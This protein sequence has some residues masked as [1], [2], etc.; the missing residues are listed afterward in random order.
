M[1]EKARIIIID[2]DAQLVE[3]LK[4]YLENKGHYVK[5]ALNSEQALE[6]LQK[7]EFDI[8][9]CDYNLPD[10]KGL[11]LAMKIAEKYP[12]TVTVFVTG[13]RSMGLAMEAMRKGV[14]DYIVKPIDYDELDK[15]IEEILQE[16]R[17]FKEGRE[18]EQSTDFIEDEGLQKS[19]S[20]SGRDK[21]GVEKSPQGKKQRE[22]GK[23]EP[24][25][26]PRQ[27]A[28]EEY[29]FSEVEDKE[30]TVFDFVID[31]T[32]ERK[33]Q[34]LT[35][36]FYLTLF[37]VAFS[38]VDTFFLR[39]TVV[40]RTI[41][42]RI[43]PPSLEIESIPSGANIELYTESGRN[44]VRGNERT[45]AQIESITPGRYTLSLTKDGYS[46]VEKTVQVSETDGEE[47]S[48]LIPGSERE[49][50]DRGTQRFTIPFEVVFNINSLPSG[51]QVFI[52]D[53]RM[54]DET[55]VEIEM[56]ID[57]YNIVLEKEGYEHLGSKSIRDMTGRCLIDL[58]PGSDNDIDEESWD[59]ER[60]AGKINL[61]GRFW[62]NV[63]VTSDPEGANV[64][65]NDRL[66]GR[67]PLDERMFS[68]V[69]QFRFEKNGFS[70]VTKEIE[71]PEQTS[72][73]ALLKRR[74]TFRA[75]DSSNPSRQLS[76]EL[77]ID[78]QRITGSTPEEVELSPGTYSVQFRNPPDYSRWSRNITIRDQNTVT[79]NMQ[80]RLHSLTVQAMDEKDDTP[81][82]NASVI[83]G[84]NVVATTGGDGKA[85][86]NITLQPHTIKITADGYKDRT[87]RYEN[88]VPGDNLKIFLKQSD[89]E[90]EDV[91]PEPVV[92]E[93]DDPEISDEP[94]MVIIDTRP[95]F[96]GAAIY[97][98]EERI[99]R[100]I[101]R[102]P[103]LQGGEHRIAIEHPYTGRVES[104]VKI[105]GGRRNIVNFDD[106]GE[107]V[108]K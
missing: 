82:A 50:T 14:H 64:Y 89:E 18:T 86:I 48:I 11:E 37:F 33:K 12:D 60:E 31:K 57:R 70:S 42:S 28:P 46:S 27:A 97:L 63:S 69:H 9:L 47:H 106:V 93:D 15:V 20:I 1:S 66:I 96:P 39:T 75:R 76:A 8:A 92:R 54:G 103:E 13:V 104:T 91:E 94:A 45:P 73:E 98:N 105:E 83:I 65:K 74:V 7:E 58:R 84:G 88:P 34:L 53:R 4:L 36:L 29:F 44:I 49:Y 6:K 52:N 61:T 81:I 40:G 30:K 87:E 5:G 77:Y 24:G 56:P 25:P 51:A 3:V 17:R 71:I 85:E 79:A 99:G 90:V 32:R 22:A 19:K 80:R 62:K 41:R 67:T 23:P 108:I 100:T 16:K 35:G 68:G 78:G 38:F 10:I 59:Y 72:V 102:V 101:R 21:V 26:D 95:N 43:W 107:A 2:D 55:P